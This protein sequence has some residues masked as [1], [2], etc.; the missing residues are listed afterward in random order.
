MLFDK[1]LAMA[2]DPHNRRVRHSIVAQDYE[3]DFFL[4]TL[5][6]LPWAKIFEA[7]LVGLSTT[8]AICRE[9][10]WISGLLRSND[11]PVMIGGIHATFLPDEAVQFADYLVRGE[12]E[13]LMFFQNYSGLGC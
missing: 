3:V 10:Y 11:I 6:S 13:N 5:D 8:T 1:F 4:G 7:D 9:A 12:Q 2:K